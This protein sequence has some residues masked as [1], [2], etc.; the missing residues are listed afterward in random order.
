MNT[1]DTFIRSLPRE[2]SD[3]VFGWLGAGEQRETAPFALLSNREPIADRLPRPDPNDP[4]AIRRVGV[5]GGGTAGY[6]TALALRVKRPWLEVTLVESPTIPIIGVGEAT[7]PGMVMFL[8]HYLDIDPAELYRRVQP[9]WKLGIYFD[10]GPQP[11]GFMA[12]FDWDS[13][14]V[15]M[16]GALE[17]QGTIDGFTLQAQLM[18]AGRAPVFE[19]DGE[20][21]SLMKYLPFAY[22]LDNARFVA[23]LTELAKE[24]GVL[25]VEAQLSD[26]VTSGEEWVDHLVTTDGRSLDYDFYVDCTGFRSMIL[27]RALGTKFNS[28]ADALFTDSAVTGNVPHDGK[29]TP[30]TSAVTM[31]SGWCWGIPTP[32]NDHHGYVYSSAAI[33]DDEAAAELARKYPGISA[34]RQVRFRIGRHDKAW[35]GNVMAIGNSYAFVEPL[36][37]TGLLMITS[38]IQTMIASLPGSWADADAR[39]MVNIGIADRWEAIRWFLSIHYKFNTRKDTPFWRHVRADASVAGAQPMLDMFASGAPLQNRNP[40]VRSYALAG[41]PTFYGLAGV[42]TILLGQQ[43][44]CRKLPS[45]EPIEKWQARYDAAASLVKRALPHHEALAAFRSTPR[46][47]EEL[48]ADADSWAGRQVAS[49]VG[50]G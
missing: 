49:Q 34:P 15:G 8:H 42:D 23:Y 35:R 9:T 41:A 5:I 10:W 33:S 45:L 16:M 46:L 17:K 36:E 18:A 20:L 7:T 30:Y 29:L 39:E 12:P 50:L 6:L 2:E 37:S 40:L 38:S 47:N 24:R 28:Y 21:V 26:V 19:H 25:H 27:E 4:R 31:D 13:N 43:V 1:L 44:P 3:A 32:E 22:H 14:S 11:Q 48:L